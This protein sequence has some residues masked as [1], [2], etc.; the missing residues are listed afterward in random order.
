VPIAAAL[1]EAAIPFRAVEL[2]PLQQRPE[3]LD[4]L[5][6]ARALVNP[7]D[8]VAWLGLLRAPWCGLSLQDLHTLVSADDPELL[9][10]PVPELLDE[11]RLLLS[12]EGQAAADRVLGTLAFAET[13]R[14]AQPTVSPGTFLEQVWLRM[15]GAHCV[16]ALGR[17]N[18]DLLW[19]ALDKLPEGE[20]DLF[21]PALG[22]ALDKL[23]ALPD[24]AGDNDCGVQLMTIHKSKGLEFE[25]VIV[26]ELQ[27]KTAQGS[28]KLLS[29][30]ERGVAEPGISD[31]PTE[32]LVAPLQS[33]G[34]ERSSAKEWVDRIY[35]ERERQEMR[36]L[37]YVAATRAREELHLCARPSYKREKDGSLS[38]AEP[39]ESLLATAWPAL[40]DEVHNR[41]DTWRTAAEPA[42]IASLAAAGEKASLSVPARGTPL[43]RLPA[44]FRMEQER[45]A[46]IAN[47]TRI[48]GAGQFYERHEGGVLSRAL[49]T[50]V[51]ALFEELA[52]LLVK[53][54]WEEARHALAQMEPWIAA[55]VR[56]AGVERAQVA[57]L[58]AKA[59][60][61][62]LAASRD[63]AGQWI[64]S[65]H[66]EAASEVRWAGVVAGNL[67]TVQ[68]DRIFRAGA[69][70]QAAGDSAWWV[71]DYKTAHED[72]VDAASA[73]PALRRIFAPQLDAYA[74]ILRNLHG[75]EVSVCAGLYYPRMLQLDWWEV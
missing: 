43:W 69:L 31:E 13:L 45:T 2:E 34:S 50:A 72:D 27:A 52:R 11:R 60:E 28:L 10:R 14:F 18:A 7:Q 1:R 3:V 5:A 40:E 19:S 75:A 48:V 51:H 61:T 54:E 33:K 44:D 39:R 20:Q 62:V 74:R 37:L 15:G 66:P 64:L 71:I 65:P 6:L 23:M 17:A 16:D 41:F 57:R 56:S 26:P 58:A 38:L 67:R 68:V 59:M 9:A 70:P 32:F 53:K 73:L 63:P 47:E 55:Q 49:G 8:R 42:T 25:V 46:A 29:W 24:P 22:A 21:G 12:S 30:L 4:A 35:R 36:R